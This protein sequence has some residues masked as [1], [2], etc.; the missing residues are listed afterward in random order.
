M[1]AFFEGFNGRIELNDDHLVI[2]KANEQ[3]MNLAIKNST[4][5]EPVV[6]KYEN[7]KKIILTPCT[8]FFNGFIQII[9]ND[10]LKDSTRFTAHKDNY[11]VVFR[12]KSFNEEAV[13]FKRKIEEQVNHIKRDSR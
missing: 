12:N 11:T 13:E 4:A 8:L 1:N 9:D 5:K 6:I 3:M 7:I 2:I 10:G